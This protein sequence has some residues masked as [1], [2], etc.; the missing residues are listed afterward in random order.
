MA[1]TLLALIAL[2]V[3]SA[4]CNSAQLFSRQRLYGIPLRLIHL[5]VLIFTVMQSTLDTMAMV[6]YALLFFFIALDIAQSSKP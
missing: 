4:M 1:S 5:G 3:L 2:G 6:G